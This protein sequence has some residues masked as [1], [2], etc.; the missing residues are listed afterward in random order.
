MFNINKNGIY[1]TRSRF[2]YY[3]EQLK[4]LEGEVLMNLSRELASS[5]GSGMG[6]PL[7]LPI[8]DFARR[9]YAEVEKIKHILTYSKFIDD[10]EKPKDPLLVFLGATVLLRDEELGDEFSYLILDADETNPSQGVI[11]YKSPL[12]S[13]LIGKKNGDLITLPNGFHYR[14]KS[15]EYKPLNLDYPITDWTDILPSQTSQKSQKH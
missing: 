13:E 3:Q 9:F 15:I 2:D 6:R 14:I 11:S 1:I 10:L 12:G 8:H 5:P 7:D 4:H